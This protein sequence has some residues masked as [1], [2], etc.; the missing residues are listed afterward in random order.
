M[1]ASWRGSQLPGGGDA[2]P[3]RAPHAGQAGLAH[4]CRPGAAGCSC[5]STP[6]RPQTSCPRSHRWESCAHSI[7]CSALRWKQRALRACTARILPLG[8]AGAVQAAPL[9]PARVQACD[10][11]QCAAGRG[12][13]VHLHA[14]DALHGDAGQG[15]AFGPVG[16][17]QREDD[18][19][20]DA[21]QGTSHALGCCGWH[22]CR[23]RCPLS[24]AHSVLQQVQTTEET[25]EG[26]ASAAAALG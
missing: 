5:Q 17:A 3:G 9:A 16:V 21:L 7:T 1:Q 4:T 19:G 10:A 13:P 24:E 11:T 14:D 25:G 20:A 8:A 6:W 15:K 12:P 22:A 2:R 18:V 26:S 23:L